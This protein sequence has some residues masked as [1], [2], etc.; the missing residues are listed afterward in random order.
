MYRHAKL[1]AGLVFIAVFSPVSSAFAQQMEIPFSFAVSASGAATISVPLPIGSFQNDGRFRQ[2]I[3]YN[4]QS[5]EGKLGVGWS[6]APYE[7]IHVCPR[8]MAHD[9]YV[10]GIRLDGKDP[11]CLNGQRL[12][13]VVG[14]YGAPDT[15]YATEL[16]SFTRIIGRQWAQDNWDAQWPFDVTLRTGEKISFGRGPKTSLALYASWR[17]VYA[18]PNSVSGPGGARRDDYNRTIGSNGG[19]SFYGL[20]YGADSATVSFPEQYMHYA[21][22]NG[23]SNGRLPIDSTGYVAELGMEMSPRG[24]IPSILIKNRKYSDT[25][26][27]PTFDGITYFLFGYEFDA[28]ARSSHLVSITQ[29]PAAEPT[30]FPPI[31][32]TYSPSTVPAFASTI[33]SGVIDAGYPAGRAWVDVNG[34]GRADFCRVIGSSGNYRV[35]CTLSTGSGF[36]TTVTSTVI[37]PGVDDGRFWRDV[38]GDGRADFCRLTAVSG[39]QGRATCTLSTETGFGSTIIS[40]MVPIGDA[41]TRDWVDA[42][43]DGRM[44]FC[45]Y[46]PSASTATCLL[47]VGNGFGVDYALKNAPSSSTMEAPAWV[48]ITN[49]GM[50]EFCRTSVTSTSSDIVCNF[51]AEPMNNAGDSTTSMS[52]LGKELG[53]VSGRVFKDVNG[54]GL[55]DFC[56][57]IGSSGSNKIACQLAT[58]LGRFSGQRSVQNTIAEYVSQTLDP[59]VPENRIWKDV[60]GD[61]RTDFCRIVL[62][63]GASQ[64]QCTLATKGTFD[65]TVVSA[66]LNAGQLAGRDFADFTGDGKLD[67][68]RVTG[69]ANSVDT[70]LECTPLIAEDARVAKIR[71]GLGREITFVYKPLTDISVYTKDANAVYPQRDV[72]KPIYVVAS[73]TDTVGG[74]SNTTQYKYGGLKEDLTGRGALGFRWVESRQVESG[75]TVRTEYRQD[76]PYAGRVA[77]VLKTIANGGSGGKISEITNT[78]AC[79]DVTTG[80]NCVVALGKRYF[81][82]VSQIVD[83]SWDLNG[84]AFPTITTSNQYDVWGNLTKQVRASSDGPVTTTVN[85]YAND[86]TNWFIGQLIRSEVT[87]TTP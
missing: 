67:F 46:I 75:I 73:V 15:R 44:D 87:T 52:W 23:E 70:R 11:I 48:E 51:N 74:L 60:N 27:S 76:F 65:T 43:A 22:F 6:L 58:G 19:E 47:S 34:D 1:A 85:T 4:S 2:S 29:R 79:I 17:F 40:G 54:D 14:E 57:I 33:T 13:N 9:G 80:S 42:N 64:M 86:T 3:E 30:G 72:Q 38:N 62:S 10:R 32:L 24:R 77:K 12:M 63:N 25:S 39:D 31:T 37:D 8:T 5:G 21:Y 18:I 50:A 16:E 84:A 41:K 35:A 78:Y 28:V 45:R 81:P 66:A 36:G 55:A 69:N 71:S 20:W 59:G 53:D 7:K 82:Y 61:G 83:A 56:R 26:S 49:D 68:C